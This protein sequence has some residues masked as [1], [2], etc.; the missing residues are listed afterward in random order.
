[1][2]GNAFYGAFS[3]LLLPRLL[4]NVLSNS[5]PPLVHFLSALPPTPGTKSGRLW[6]VL[7]YCLQEEGDG[8]C[9]ASR[10]SECLVG[11]LDS[12]SR[13]INKAMVVYRKCSISEAASCYDKSPEKLGPMQALP[14]V[15]SSFSMIPVVMEA[16][17]V[18]KLEKMKETTL[19]FSFTLYND[20][21]LPYICHT[22][23]GLQKNMVELSIL[24]FP[25]LTLLNAAC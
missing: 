9:N 23:G 19:I 8:R 1:M 18:G 17:T 6:Q 12:S 20:G 16:E 4:L 7:N 15:P 13:K 10:L 22:C 14:E 24:V 5:T 3:V 2:R 11:V 25:P 21:V